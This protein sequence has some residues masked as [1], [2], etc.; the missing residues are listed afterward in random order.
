MFV[1][2]RRRDLSSA[3]AAQL[4]VTKIVDDEEYDVVTH[5][6]LSRATFRLAGTNTPIKNTKIRSWISCREFLE[7]VSTIRIVELKRLG[8]HAQRFTCERS[9]TDKTSRFQLRCDRTDTHRLLPSVQFQKR[10]VGHRLLA[11]ALTHN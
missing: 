8:L 5:T 1:N 7:A 6:V 10:R 4:A 9:E 3:V 2:I 11:V